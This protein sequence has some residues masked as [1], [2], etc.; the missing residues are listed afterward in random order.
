MTNPCKMVKIVSFP[1]HFLSSWE[2]MKT[3]MK[4]KIINVW[5]NSFI[6]Y[7]SNVSKFIILL[8]RGDI[9]M[10]GI[11]PMTLYYFKNKIFT[12]FY[13][14]VSWCIWELSKYVSWNISTRR[15][16]IS[17]EKPFQ[18]KWTLQNRKKSW[19]CQNVCEK[20]RNR[21]EENNRK[22][23]NMH[24]KNTNLSKEQ[25]DKIAQNAHKQ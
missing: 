2:K 5:S 10:T 19:K 13:I 21:T 6:E 11:K 16:L 9:W 18:K 24:I 17:I 12:D 20:Y 25:N 8:Q 22:G 15:C 23:V 7:E 3:R 4:K 1:L 14:S